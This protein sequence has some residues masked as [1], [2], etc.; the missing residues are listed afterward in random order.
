MYTYIYI[1]VTHVHIYI[2]NQYIYYSHPILAI[3]M[4]MCS[5]VSIM[6]D[7]IVYR[8]V[9]RTSSKC[10]F[11]VLEAGTYI[12]VDMLTLC[13]LVKCV[14]LYCLPT[15]MICKSWINNSVEIAKTN[16]F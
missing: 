5:I 13:K 6:L 2:Y 4:T 16:R 14:S 8:I 12:N 10:S 9:E 15:D 7:I 1:K 11:S 3:Y